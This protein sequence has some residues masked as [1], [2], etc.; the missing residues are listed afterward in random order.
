MLGFLHQRALVDDDMVAIHHTR[1]DSGL[2]DFVL[3]PGIQ[4]I[5]TEH[6][7]HGVGMNATVPVDLQQHVIMADHIHCYH[8]PHHHGGHGFGLTSLW[9]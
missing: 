5:G 2:G 4:S 1:V 7:I 8:L 9:V 6:S 3:I